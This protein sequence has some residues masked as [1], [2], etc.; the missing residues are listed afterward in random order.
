MDAP[1]FIDLLADGV[2]TIRLGNV[3]VQGIAIMHSLCKDGDRLPVDVGTLSWVPIRTP[4]HRRFNRPGWGVALG[5]VSEQ[6]R[7][8]CARTPLMRRPSVNRITSLS[9]PPAPR[10]RL[11]RKPADHKR[12]LKHAFCVSRNP[13]TEP[14]VSVTVRVSVFSHPESLSEFQASESV[15][16]AATG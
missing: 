3:P 10:C 13:Y 4:L 15:S 11:G 7:L 6:T 8:K 16:S 9:E 12:L 14:R 5:V 1:N 2:T